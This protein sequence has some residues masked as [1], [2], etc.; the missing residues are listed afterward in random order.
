MARGKEGKVAPTT[1]LIQFKTV[2]RLPVYSP[3]STFTK[4]Y[5]SLVSKNYEKCILDGTWSNFSIANMVPLISKSLTSW[6]DDP[7]RW[8]S[9]DE[10][11]QFK[12]IAG[13]AIDGI[14]NLE[15][16]IRKRAQAIPE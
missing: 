14:V 1:D 2:L 7:L 6:N 4:C 11:E 16:S 13:F 12:T 10:Y 8:K 9:S 15:T 5:P 3:R